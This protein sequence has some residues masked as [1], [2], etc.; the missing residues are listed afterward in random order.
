MNYILHNRCQSMDLG[1]ESFQKVLD[2]IFREKSET[3][4]SVNV[5]SKEIHNS[6]K[7]YSDHNQMP[8]CCRV[9]RNN[10]T[11]DDHFVTKKETDHAYLEICYSLPR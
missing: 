8:N 7:N 3:H 10:M 6:I 1:T 2:D 5:I 9:M 4:N 11:E